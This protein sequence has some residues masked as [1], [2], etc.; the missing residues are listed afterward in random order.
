METLSQK[1]PLN[2][3][4]F[5]TMLSE[6]NPHSRQAKDKIRGIDRKGRQ[7][8]LAGATRKGSVEERE[9]SHPEEGSFSFLEHIRVFSYL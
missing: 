1:L 3:L 2:G 5:P 4:C 9:E 8:D 7:E 6:L